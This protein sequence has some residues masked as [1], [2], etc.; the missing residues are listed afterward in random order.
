MDMFGSEFKFNI[1]NRKRYKTLFGTFL[2]LISVILIGLSVYLFVSNFYDTKSPQVTVSIE[3][4]EV[5]PQMDLFS[6]KIFFSFSVFNGTQ[7]VPVD[8]IEKF[9]TLEVIAAKTTLPNGAT[10]PETAHNKVPYGPC[11]DLI[12]TNQY[13]KAA[14]EGEIPKELIPFALCAD[15]QDQQQ[16]DGLWTI[17][18]NLLS[19][20][21]ELLTYYIYPCSLDNPSV[22]CASKEE[23]M[24]AKIMMPFQVKS[25]DFSDKKTP[26]STGRD[27]KTEFFFQEFSRTNMAIYFKK[28]QIIDDDRDFRAPQRTHDFIDIEKILNAEAMRD[29][30]FVCTKAEI[31]DFSCSPY[32]QVDLRSGTAV[33]TI[34]RSYEKLFATISELGGFGDLI[35]IVL[36]FFYAF[37]NEYFYNKWLKNEVLRLKQH[38]IKKNQAFLRRFIGN[39]QKMEKYQDRVIERN[40]D[41]IAFMKK[42]QKMDLLFDLFFDKDF[43]CLIPLVQLSQEKRKRELRIHPTFGDKE[44]SI[45]DKIEQLKMSARGEKNEL[46]K[47]IKYA[48]L[49]WLGEGG[50]F[51]SKAKGGEISSYGGEKVSVHKIQKSKMNH[52]KLQKKQVSIDRRVAPAK[53]KGMKFKVGRMSSNNLVIK[54]YGQVSGKRGSDAGESSGKGTRDGSE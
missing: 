47:R 16:V 38:Q 40:L 51:R 27:S 50:E 34:Q 21:Y 36:G 15:A 9:I 11:K 52:M 31:D 1:K 45:E 4:N 7:F 46:K 44:N 48:I 32:V 39:K 6:E 33:S 42:M 19:P 12:E 24:N 29:G 13:T 8:E 3:Q 17:G 5:S 23:L 43:D 14:F 18:G 37:Y 28:N 22:N 35:Y 26:V 49:G 25:L 30:T 10:E 2:T 54:P 20:P 53:A 41:S